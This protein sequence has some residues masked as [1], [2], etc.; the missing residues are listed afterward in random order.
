MM[1][2][3]YAGDR[4]ATHPY[5]SPLNGDFHGP[6]GRWANLYNIATILQVTAT[7]G[8]MSLGVALVIG[9]GEIDISVG[10]TF[11]MGALT[12]LWLAAHVD[13][14]VSA[15]AAIAVGVCFGEIR[16][17]RRGTSREECAAVE[18]LS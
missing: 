15:L 9:T 18:E 11:G 17:H 5:V 13:P 3:A 10:S 14:S 8:L 12:Y 2:P 1:V 7:L 16:N 4:D 6:D